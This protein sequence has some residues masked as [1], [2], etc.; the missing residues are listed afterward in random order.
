[1][2]TTTRLAEDRPTNT[3]T[4]NGS[5]RKAEYARFLQSDF[6]INL[7]RT[8]R[9][10]IGRCQ[11]C[12]SKRHLQAH[13]VF[14]RSDWY[15][16]QLADLKVLCRVCHEIEHGIRPKLKPPQPTRRKRRHKKQPKWMRQTFRYHPPKLRFRDYKPKHAWSGTVSDPVIIP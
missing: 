2:D 3:Q 16:T 9:D 12:G 13:H 4:G 1:M 15:Q 7:S 14:Y 6:W 5:N 11:H 8:K 10:Q